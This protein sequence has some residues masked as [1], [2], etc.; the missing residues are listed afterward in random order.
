MW[1]VRCNDCDWIGSD[2]ELD[3][4]QVDAEDEDGDP[5]TYERC[6]NCYGMEAIM[7][8][9]SGCFFSEEQI[10]TLW[11]LLE[12]IPMN[13]ETEQIEE[14]FLGFDAGTEREAV[15]HW[16]DERYPGGVHNLMYGGDTA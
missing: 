14:P 10:R 12:D 7:D 4:L 13:P 6:P 11:K 9:D 1:I 16:F 8:V 2:D 15:W 3:I 5:I